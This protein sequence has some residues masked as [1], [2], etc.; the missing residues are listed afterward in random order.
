MFQQKSFVISLL[1][2][3]SVEKHFLYPFFPL[4]SQRHSCFVYIYNFMK[5][6][7][8]ITRIKISWFQTTEGTFS[9]PVENMFI[10]SISKHLNCSLK[11]G[12][13]CRTRLR[14]LARIDGG[15]E[16]E[17]ITKNHLPQ[18]PLPL[19]THLCLYCLILVTQK[20]PLWIYSQG[21]LFPHC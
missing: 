20:C 21:H 17:N 1:F 15:K 5:F 11:Q 13:S 4:Y 18:I 6:I 12:V 2:F 3:F 10:G 8:K 9:Y 19:D 16:E 14:Q 7:L